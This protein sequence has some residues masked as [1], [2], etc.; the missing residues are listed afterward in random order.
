[1]KAIVLKNTSKDFANLQNNL[2]VTDFPER[3][4]EDNEI[5]IKI[6]YAALNHRDLWITKG[7]YAGIKLPVILGSDCSGIITECGKNVNN[8]KSGDEVI[9]NPSFN[10]GSC[11]NFQSK[12]FK[13]LGLPDN[14]TLREYISI[15]R[16][17]VY[18][19]PQHLK[20]EEAAA[21]PLAGLTAFRAVF[22]KGNI[23]KN[24]K[25][26]ITGIG[27][28]V[29][30]FALLFSAAEG[31]DVF[32][33]SGSPD[34]ISKAIELGAKAGFIYKN[35]NWTKDLMN[36]SGGGIDLIIDGTGGGNINSIMNI[37]NPG[38][39]IINYGATL[40]NIPDFDLRKLFW[41]QIK[42]IGTTMGSDKDFRE[43]IEYIT[44]KK[45]RPVIDT[46]YNFD[47]YISAFER[48]EN[49][50]QMGKILIRIS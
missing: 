7:L 23:T 37:I 35:D 19:K 20:L 13:I 3:S 25:V 44:N 22:Q 4:L 34:K 14:G 42:L 39:R 11:E 27:G 1:M 24:D 6:E 8:F 30:A 43:M 50:R 47:D 18:K 17:Y 10:W 49:S 21:I 12:D 33:T 45:I 2:I 48:M 29:S 46:I 31:A 16:K 36:F 38:G 41:K 9:I 28:G 26:L 40:G 32:V 15:D 5:R